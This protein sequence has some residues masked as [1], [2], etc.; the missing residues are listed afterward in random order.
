M[1]LHFNWAC[2][3]SFGEKLN[4]KHLTRRGGVMTMQEDLCRNK[5]SVP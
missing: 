5:Y 3:G 1:V 4:Y 2:G